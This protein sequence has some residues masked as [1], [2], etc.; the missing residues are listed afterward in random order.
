MTT[1]LLE[2]AAVTTT[3][4]ETAAAT[5]PPLELAAATTLELV[6]GEHRTPGLLRR[7]GVSSGRKAGRRT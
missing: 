3:E 7:G 6:A 4:L 1:P 5:I 2:L